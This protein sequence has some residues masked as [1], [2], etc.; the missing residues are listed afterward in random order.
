MDAHV[1][2]LDISYKTKSLEAGLVKKKL[3]REC[4]KRLL[5]CFR[6]PLLPA[7]PGEHEWRTAGAATAT[8]ACVNPHWGVLQ[9]PQYCLLTTKA[10]YHDQHEQVKAHGIEPGM[11]GEGD[12]KWHG[13]DSRGDIPCC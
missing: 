8:G 4:R 3:L 2:V 5:T 1:W 7:L 11:V 6:M 10:F 13:G 12:C 9:S